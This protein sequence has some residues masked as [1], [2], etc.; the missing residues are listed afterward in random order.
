MVMETGLVGHMYDR[1][2]CMCNGV[3]LS[4]LPLQ[5]SA[6]QKKGLWRAITKDVQTLMAYGRRSTR[7]WKRWEDLK[8]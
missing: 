7:Y 8:R 3:L 6:H 2:D 4:V 5:V 1:L